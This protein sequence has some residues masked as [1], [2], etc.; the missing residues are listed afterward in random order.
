MVESPASFPRTASVSPSVK[1]SSCAEPWF[2]NGSTARTFS[3][4][5]P[6]LSPRWR[7]QPTRTPSPM[8]IPS[9]RVSNAVGIFRRGVATVPAA[10]DGTVAP[11]RSTP[12]SA[13]PNSAAVA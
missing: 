8:R 13:S 7:S 9:T 12:A 11:E 10:N 5:S 2:S 4:P 1:Y 3:L 6:P